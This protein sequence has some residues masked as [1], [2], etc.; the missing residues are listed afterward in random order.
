MLIE[1]IFIGIF[2]TSWVKKRYQLSFILHSTPIY[3]LT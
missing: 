3:I 1:I 2:R